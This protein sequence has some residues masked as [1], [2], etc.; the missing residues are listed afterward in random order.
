MSP[1][2]VAE[3]DRQLVGVAAGYLRVVS[4]ALGIFYLVRGISYF[5]TLPADVAGLLAWPIL[6]SSLFCLLVFFF[7]RQKVPPA[8]VINAI[9]MIIGAMLI[10]NVF[11]NLY[12][13]QNNLQILAATIAI[14]AFGVLTVNVWVWLFHVVVC[15]VAF[16]WAMVY[17]ETGETVQQL[18]L[19]FAGIVLSAVVYRSR[20]PVIKE[21]LRLEIKL[22]ADAEK[23]REANKTKDQFI[24]NMTHELR[25]PLTGV[26]G[27][28]NL[29][30]ETKL[31]S[32][33]QFMLQNAQK[34]A[35][36]L[37]NVI[38]DILDF[39]GLEAGKVK[40]RPA[41]VDLLSVCKDAVAVFDAQ[42]RDK[43]LTLRF[44]V[45]NYEN[46]TVTADGVRIGQI[47]MNFIGNAVKFTDEGGVTVVLEWEATETGGIAK[48]SVEDT[49]IGVDN[50]MMEKLFH[51]FERADNSATR[52]ASGTGLGLAICQELVCLMGGSIT[53]ASN[54][55]VGS[56]FCF[57][58]K[59]SHAEIVENKPLA[60]QIRQQTVSAEANTPS[61]N[62]RVLLAEDNAINQTLIVRM[63]EQEGMDV[64]LVENGQE[65]V[66]AVD[67]EEKPFDIIFL[68]IQ[69]PVLDG[70][71]AARI[72][73]LRSEMPP[74]LI[75]ITAN[76]SESDLQSYK[77][78]GIY[79]VLGKPLNRGELRL[80]VE[81]LKNEE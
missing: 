34:S 70:V 61:S 48:F 71:S 15:L 79:E 6:T 3:Y 28:M 58:L 2:E 20:T 27:M 77:E 74:P 76:T 56:C 50:A 30:E 40:L 67:S 31:D 66:D 47:L 80:V 11:W 55:S 41:Q 21:R 46:L 78:V 37:M 49:G 12:L 26:M 13:T 57:E 33:Q 35:Q 63:L 10:F 16:G 14:I 25:T 64:T 73:R 65:A 51:R 75:A 44:E 22:Q 36:Y 38:N 43:G 53:V 72:I 4:G 81:N 45:P 52:V 29:M 54:I 60:P 5:R 17:L 18:S 69:M 9:S 19:L 23:L 8:R 7:T 24:A 62:L 68:D 32:E 42:V 39:S 1:S 59:F